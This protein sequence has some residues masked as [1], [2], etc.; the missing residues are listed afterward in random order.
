MYMNN[1]EYMLMKFEV[2]GKNINLFEHHLNALIDNS[3][4]DVYGDDKVTHHKNGVKFDNR[5]E[6]LEIMD[7]SDHRILHLK[8]NLHQDWV[9][10]KISKSKTNKLLPI[11]FDKSNDFN[12]GGRYVSEPYIKKGKK[13]KLSSVDLD[14]CINKVESFINSE[15]NTYSYENWIVL[16][17][18]Y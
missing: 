13:K 5:P 17:D 18:C 8:D 12:K 3:L 11:K 4:L 6:N 10:D 7:D 2:D 14:K 16:L 15:E 1:Y 9:R